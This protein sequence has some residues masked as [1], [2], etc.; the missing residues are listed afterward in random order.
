M[1]KPNSA[2]A[3]IANK[4]PHKTSIHNTSWIDDYFWMRLTDEQKEAESKDS[5][6]QEVLDYLNAENDYREEIMSDTK[7]LQKTLYEEITSRIEQRLE[8]PAV[9]KNGYEYRI[10]YEEDQDYPL[11]LRKS[12]KE[13]SLDEVMLNGPELAKD[14]A[15]FQIGGRSVSPDNMMLAYGVDTVSR[16][17]YK[18]KF[19]SLETGETFDYSIE[20]TTGNAVWANDNKTLFYTK[21]DPQTLRSNQVFRHQLGDDPSN[22]VLVFT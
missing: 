16:R 21:K 6:T 15:Y 5:Q 11:Y 2:K 4:I 3:P 10:K 22:D 9:R 19:K 14:H 12:L 8:T 7:A 20:N 17:Q 1:K 18:I 13:G